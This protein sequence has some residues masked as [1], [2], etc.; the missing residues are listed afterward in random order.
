MTPEEARQTTNPEKPQVLRI[1]IFEDSEPYFGALQLYLKVG[2]ITLERIA[3]DMDEALKAIPNLANKG[4]GAIL[5]DG[6]LT[7]DDASGSDGRRIVALIKQ[8]ELPVTIIGHSGSGDVEGADYQL[9]KI[10]GAPKVE[11][12]LRNI[13]KKSV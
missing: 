4:F 9:P 6:N 13:L 10:E 12:L 1:G 8:L 5:V 2:G 7:P 3:S 11:A